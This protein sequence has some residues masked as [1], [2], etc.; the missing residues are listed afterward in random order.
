[1]FDVIRSPNGGGAYVVVLVPS[2]GASISIK[3][4]AKPTN[5]KVPPYPIALLI[6]K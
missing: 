2:V 3:F 6:R 5:N 1:M 4:E